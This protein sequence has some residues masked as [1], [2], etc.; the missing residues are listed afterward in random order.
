MLTDRQT[1]VTNLIV[2]S[3][4]LFERPHREGTL[5]KK[6]YLRVAV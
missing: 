6:F 3:R 2:A 5:V 4:N 1:D